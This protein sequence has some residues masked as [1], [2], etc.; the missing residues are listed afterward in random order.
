VVPIHY[1]IIVELACVHIDMLCRMQVCISGCRSCNL[2]SQRCSCLKPLRSFLC[3]AVAASCLPGQLRKESCAYQEITSSSSIEQGK[4]KKTS[5]D[6][7][8]WLLEHTLLSDSVTGML[9]YRNG[10]RHI[11]PSP[12]QSALLPVNLYRVYLYMSACWD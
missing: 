6:L 8:V 1:Q 5:E 7:I 9:M 11:S 4:P 12:Q 2:L 10:A 3:A